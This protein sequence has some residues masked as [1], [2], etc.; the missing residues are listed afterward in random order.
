[1][2]MLLRCLECFASNAYSCFSKAALTSMAVVKVLVTISIIVIVAVKLEDVRVVMQVPD[3]TTVE[4]LKNLTDSL[5]AISGGG[6]IAVMQLPPGAAAS[7]ASSPP[8]PPFA[9]F[10]SETTDFNGAAGPFHVNASCLLQKRGVPPQ[11]HHYTRTMCSYVYAVSGLS[12]LATFAMACLL[13]CT[14]HLCGVG[15][16]LELSFALLGTAWWLAAALVLQENT[17]VSVDARDAVKQFIFGDAMS[18]PPPLGPESLPLPSPPPSQPPPPLGHD[19]A[20]QLQALMQQYMPRSLQQWRHALVGL[21]WAMMG[22][23][24]A[25]SVLML[26]EACGCLLDCCTCV[27]RCC[28]CPSR[29]E[30][31][32]R[33]NFRKRM[34]AGGEEYMEMMGCCSDLCRKLFVGLLSLIKVG[35]ST[36]II[37]IVAVHLYKA[38]ITWKKGDLPEVKPSCLMTG[39]VRGESVCEYTFAVCGLSML[40]SMVT[41]LLLCVTC[42]LC[43]LGDWFQFAVQGLQTAW[44]V[45]AAIII[46]KNVRDSNEYE[47]V[48]LPKEGWRDAVAVMSWV[49]AGIAFLCAVIFLIQVSVSVGGLGAC[50]CLRNCC[51]CCCGGDGDGDDYAKRANV[52]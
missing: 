46:S 8:S 14:C 17:T 33:T 22:M 29:P 49:N 10:G 34:R 43:G 3:L 16:I 27:C 19:T 7:D 32:W 9:P 1:M 24:A 6:E 31:R 41:S 40:L 21:C 52:V 48:G 47:G 35:V 45:I 42:D 25:S 50:N 51:S 15:P 44:W 38:D 39:S 20:S 18:P 37:V 13:W 30:S 11:I 12:L 28:C 26:I 36:A 4:G 2:K 23:F 5:M